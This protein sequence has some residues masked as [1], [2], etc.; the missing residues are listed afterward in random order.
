MVDDRYVYKYRFISLFAGVSFQNF[1]LLNCKTANSRAIF[2]TE[3]KGH[4]VELYF[5]VNSQKRE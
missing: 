1:L 2:N 4:Q 3:V 5:N